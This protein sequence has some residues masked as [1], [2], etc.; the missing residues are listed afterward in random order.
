MTHF[1]LDITGVA[2]RVND[3]DRMVTFYEN[4][5]G[6]SVF[7]KDKETATLGIGTKLMLELHLDPH[8]TQQADAPGLF[9]TAFLLPSRGDLGAWLGQAIRQK[10]QLDGASNHG[11]SEAIY[12]TDPEGNGVEI[13]ADSP[14]HSW[15]GPDGKLRGG[16]KMLDVQELLSSS[17]IWKGTPTDTRIGHV[18]LQVGNLNVAHDVFA[19]QLSL[20][21]MSKMPGMGFYGTGG[22]HHHFG[23]NTHHSRG[24][25]KP[26]GVATGLISIGLEFE[27]SKNLPEVIDAPWGTRFEINKRIK[28]AA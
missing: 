24:I 20:D 10:A 14:S 28:L 13:C 26:E 11:M 16:S 6:L 9:H 17:P 22:Y 19:Y 21:V 1:G 15:I 25:D 2:L 5:V 23:V 18:H 12:L 4:V 27:D 3:L 7:K 8:A